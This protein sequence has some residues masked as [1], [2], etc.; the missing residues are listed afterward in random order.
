MR[1]QTRRAIEAKTEAKI[2]L[3]QVESEKKTT[4]RKCDASNEV[5]VNIHT[6]GGNRTGNST[7]RVLLFVSRLRMS[8]LVYS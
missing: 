8:L 4:E 2:R 7:L 5:S 3:D 1:E 6:R